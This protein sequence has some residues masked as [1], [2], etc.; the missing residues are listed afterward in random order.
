MICFLFCTKL[1]ILYVKTAFYARF[2]EVHLQAHIELSAGK[3]VGHGI[4]DAIDVGYPIVAAHVAD[5]KQVEHVKPEP[6]ALEVA[7]EARCWF[8][9]FA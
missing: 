7:E 9:A 2:L 1:V 3:V 5:V 8:V 6:N 4:L